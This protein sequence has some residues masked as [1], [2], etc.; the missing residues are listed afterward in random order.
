MKFGWF[1]EATYDGLPAGVASGT[2]N[3][4]IRVIGDSPALHDPVSLHRDPTVAGQRG[5]RRWG[6]GAQPLL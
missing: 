2:E 4:A 5:G 3:A 1:E 6:A